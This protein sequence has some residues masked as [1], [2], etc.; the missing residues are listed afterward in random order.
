MKKIK[1]KN[2]KV[3]NDR[4]KSIKTKLIVGF[5]TLVGMVCIALGISTLQNASQGVRNEAEKGLQALAYEGARFVES[6][7][8]TQKHV[9]Q[10]LASTD[11]IES[12]NWEI[13]RAELEKQVER[14]DFLALAV[15]HPDGMAY[16]N[17]G[18]TK[19]LGDRE[20]VKKALAGEVNTSELIISGVT[21]ELVLMYAAPIQK[22][23]KV[24]AAL[25]GRRDGNALSIISDTIGFGEEGYGYI[26]DST[27]T[28]VGHSNRDLV[29][30]RFNAIEQVK[31]DETVK[32]L[33]ALV[34]K[35]LEEKTGIGEYFYNG[36]HLYAGYAPI[37][38]TNWSLVITADRQEVL[39]AL[40]N[41]RRDTLVITLIILLISIASAY[42]VGNA[43][44]KPIIA[45][46]KHSKKIADLDITQNVPTDLLNKK[47]E[48]GGLSKALQSITDNLRNI[49]N[50]I[51]RSS[52]QMA[53][54]SEQMTA[55]SEQSAH[56]AEQVSKAVEE[57][58]RGASEQAQNTEEGASKAMKL[59][60]AIETDLTYIQNLSSAS[61]KVGEAIDE[62]LGEIEKLA[63]ISGESREATHKVQQGIIKTN[64]SVNKIG[65]ASTVIGFI[66]DQTNLLALNAAIE[67][68]RAGE[69]G[70]GFAVVAEEIRKLAEQ[71]TIS[72]K[73]IDEVVREL[74]NNSKASVEIM[75]NVSVILN[76]QQDRV[77]NSKNKYMSISEAIQ[78]SE[79]L[80]KKLNNSSKQMDKMKDEILSTIQNLSA[81]AEENSVST[82]EVSASVEEQTASMEEIASASEG[83][84]DL[85]QNMQTIISRFK[86]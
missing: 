19:D 10:M 4:T 17:D 50:E 2:I 32:S 36:D 69:A 57:I 61:Q 47:D 27:G 58:A 42:L 64:D 13:Q 35:V 3:K 15:V 48:I 73:A 80:V 11:A 21:N 76:E 72:T 28:V 24:V 70:R 40:S 59:G 52:E 20:Y 30:E 85:A 22:Q 86:L 54:S 1:T 37:A 82:Q 44:A 12:M 29:S 55:T 68:A 45:I 16:Y 84:A 81:I 71:S 14:T 9:L 39:G 25:I 41:L 75:E 7:V 78:A 51:S 62:G 77:E 46:T 56:A 31:E 53:S 26:L 33:A 8:E 63:K 83:L 6:R 43:I 74:Q 23:G 60:E 79:Q 18:S 5:S 65:E 34:T 67:A 49:I 38:N 66:A